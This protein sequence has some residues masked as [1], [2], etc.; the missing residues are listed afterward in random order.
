[1]TEKVYSIPIVVQPTE[2]GA[3]TYYE[4]REWIGVMLHCEGGRLST[5]GPGDAK[6]ALDYDRIECN[7]H[8][9][10]LQKTLPLDRLEGYAS[11]VL[12]KYLK[13]VVLS[14]LYFKPVFVCTFDPSDCG[15]F[16]HALFCS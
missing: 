3:D 5:T 7:G 1:M 14:N 16:L 4:A 15:D 13:S 8:Q 11:T 9:I 12:A 10:S 6:Q 2:G